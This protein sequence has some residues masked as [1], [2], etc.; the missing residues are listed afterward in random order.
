[1]Q[2]KHICKLIILSLTLLFLTKRIYLAHAEQQTKKNV[3][4][5][6]IERILTNPE[7]CQKTFSG[8][9]SVNA[10][11]VVQAIQ[12]KNR[13]GVFIDLYK[14]IN[15][16]PKAFYGQER[17]KVFDYSLSTIKGV[18]NLQIMTAQGF[19]TPTHNIIKIILNI[20]VDGNQNITDCHSMNKS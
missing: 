10:N 4:Q 18:T 16:D 9:S 12:F 5:K 11:N 13:H 19:I 1:M 8:K 20:Q 3:I 2:K 7:N 6:E 15:L 17:L 14:N